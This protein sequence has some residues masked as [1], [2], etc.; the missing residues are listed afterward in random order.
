M[1]FFEKYILFEISECL[2][3]ETLAFFSYTRHSF[4]HKN[5]KQMTQVQQWLNL[6]SWQFLFGPGKQF[7]DHPHLTAKMLWGSHSSF[8]LASFCKGFE[9]VFVFDNSVRGFPRRSFLLASLIILWKPNLPFAVCSSDLKFSR[10]KN[11][12]KKKIPPFVH[13]IQALW[14][15]FFNPRLLAKRFIM[16]Y[17]FV[18]NEKLP[19]NPS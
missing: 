3:I 7:H 14:F 4:S 9:M 8:A 13:I 19:K 17:F 1:M 12:S 10:K 15:F 2:V 5:A 16:I 18:T 11:E 6:N